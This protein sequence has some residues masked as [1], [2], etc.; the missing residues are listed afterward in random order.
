MG[1]KKKKKKE[2]EKG[3]AGWIVSFADLMTLL[4]AT[5]VVLFAFKP[6]GIGQSDQVVQQMAAAIRETFNDVPDDIPEDETA[7]PTDNGRKVFSHLRAKMMHKPVITK[8]RRTNKAMNI[9]DKKMLE[10]QDMLEKIIAS[11]SGSKDDTRTPSVTMHK[12]KDGFSLRLLATHFYRPG[13]YRVRREYLGKLDEVGK[14]LKASGNK[15]A[16]EGHTDATPARGQFNNWEISAMR[17]SFIARYFIRELGFPAGK[18][19]AAGF[20]DTKP[21]AQ[22]HSPQGRRLNRRIEIR[23]SHDE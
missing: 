19:S 4:F 12:E 18:L 15:V 9:L 22:N 6:E 3:G 16:I 13:E 10:V 8:F 17:A 23:V 2:E 1:D 21:I 11:G 5:F 7:F 14:I 20:A